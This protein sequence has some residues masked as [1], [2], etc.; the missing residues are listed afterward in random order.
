MKRN[1]VSIA[2]SIVG[3][4]YSS[5][6]PL[7]PRFAIPLRLRP[8]YASWSF[9]PERRPLL[10]STAC[11]SASRGRALWYIAVVIVVGKT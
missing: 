8:C 2:R 9:R 4:M 6:S 7:A 10:R 1:A 3:A 5:I 11:R